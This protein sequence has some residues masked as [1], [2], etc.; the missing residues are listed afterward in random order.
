MTKNEEEKQGE[1]EEE[2]ECPGLGL[3]SFSIYLPQS[4]N[5]SGYFN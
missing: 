1:K 3:G 5:Q 4:D 2:E